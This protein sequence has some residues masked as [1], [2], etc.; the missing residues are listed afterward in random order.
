MLI[1]LLALA[2]AHAAPPAPAPAAPPAAILRLAWQQG[3]AP[4][5]VRF[6]PF[7]VRVTFQVAPGHA[8]SGCAVELLGNPDAHWHDDPC[9]H[10]AAAPFLALIGL[11]EQAQGRVTAVLA[12]EANGRSVDAGA[13][14]GRRTFRTEARF[15]LGAD[16]TLMRCAMGEPVGTGGQVD[17]CQ[18]GFPRRPNPFTPMADGARVGLLSLSFYLER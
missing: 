3:T 5:A 8:V 15:E 18:A 2:A 1:S 11:D 9:R 13:V 10:I 7:V 14:S 6:A 17:L 16:G 4:P 12:L